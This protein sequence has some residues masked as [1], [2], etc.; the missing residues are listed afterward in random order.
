[1]A[2]SP[3]QGG[4]GTRAAALTYVSAGAGVVVHVVAP[5]RGGITV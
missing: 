2:R 3:G 1:M 5:G 4:G